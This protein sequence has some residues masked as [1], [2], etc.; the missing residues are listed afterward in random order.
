MNGYVYLGMAIFCEVIATSALKAS[1]E[2]SR[3]GP[4]LLVLA[5]YSGAFYALSKTLRDIPVGIA[6]AIWS[7]IGVTLVCIIAA[8]LYR[9]KLDLP[10]IFGIALIIAG[11]LVIQLFSRSAGH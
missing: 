7:G 6:Y 5:G 8:V 10:A 11:V 4:S 3:L 2:F 1:Q 9:Q